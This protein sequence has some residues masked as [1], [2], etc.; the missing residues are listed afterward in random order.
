MSSASRAFNASRTFSLKYSRSTFSMKAEREA[1][2]PAFRSTSA[3]TSGE[4]VIDV[5]SLILLTYHLSLS[6]HRHGG[7]HV[8]QGSVGVKALQLR[9]GLEHDAVAQHRQDG[10]LD[11]V[12]DEVIAAIEG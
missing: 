5:F 4:S 8:G 3:R 6:W 2:E 1:L 10:A 12:R 11:V 9:L 7:N